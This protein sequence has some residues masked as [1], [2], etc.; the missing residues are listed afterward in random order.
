MNSTVT[1]GETSYSKSVKKN[2]SSLT[3]LHVVNSEENAA[4]VKRE[5]KGRGRGVKVLRGRSS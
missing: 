4:L 5:K 3:L 2:L 1:R